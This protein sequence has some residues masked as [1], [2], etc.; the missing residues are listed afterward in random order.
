MFSNTTNTTIKIR[1]KKIKVHANGITLICKTKIGQQKI[2]FVEIDKIYLSLNKRAFIMTYLYFSIVG[3]C[4]LS[5]C[6]GI[7]LLYC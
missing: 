4:I 3:C 1:F 2:P 6:I 5:D 7:L